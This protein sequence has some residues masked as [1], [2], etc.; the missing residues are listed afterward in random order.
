MGMRFFGGG[1]GHRSTRMA[2]DDFLKDRDRLDLSLDNDAVNDAVD[3]DPEDQAESSAVTGSDSGSDSDDDDYGYGNPAD[4]DVD[5]L[6][7]DSGED[8]GDTV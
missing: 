3:S 6:D 1:I 8:V 4:E 5:P 7:S 2:T